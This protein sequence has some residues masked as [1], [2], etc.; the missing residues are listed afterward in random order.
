MDNNPF[1]PTYRLIIECCRFQPD[2]DLLSSLSAQISDWNGCLMSAY[3]H[4]VYPLVAKSLKSIK[5]LPD[6]I[7]MS[8]KLANLDIARRNM[9]MTSELLRIM[10]LFEDHNIRAM[11]IK[12]PVLSQMIHGD[13]TQRQ[14]SD[15]DILIDEPD[16]YKAGLLLSEN[17]FEM[18]H[19]IE[20]LQ[21]KTLLKIFK[22]VVFSSKDVH[23]E[24]HWRLFEEKL[25]QKVLTEQF[26]Y[27]TDVC[28]VNGVSIRT[29]QVDSMLFYLCLHGSRHFWER[30]EWIVDI[31]RLVRHNTVIDWEKLVR[32][33]QEMKTSTMFLLG[34]AM[35]QRMFDTPLPGFIQD[36]ISQ[37]T[38]IERL[39]DL[40]LKEI[41]NNEILNAEHD[42]VSWKQF[43]M[44]SI[45]H[46]N[47]WNAFDT[48]RK[49]LFQIKVTDIYTVNLPSRLA[50]LYHLI[51]PFRFIRDYV[52]F[53]R[54][55]KI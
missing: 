43:Y 50:F 51:R 11:A 35:S 21:N 48:F 6:P 28:R 39:I 27:H 36:E 9:V 26:N 8:L 42:L 15:I 10:K 30:I 31:D 24:L 34:L 44:S 16:V 12:G 2:S 49:H 46:D 45:I 55:S 19:E 18:D 38:K 4:G 37:N 13:I 3:A 5:T 33:G 29:L 1:S 25:I 23:L 40:M 7:K 32:F 22:D 52:N 41:A 14:F 20:F 54:K 53:H 47:I 17:Q